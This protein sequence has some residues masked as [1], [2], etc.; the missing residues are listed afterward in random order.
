V[1]DGPRYDDLLMDITR[2]DFGP[3]RLRGM[4]AQIRDT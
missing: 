1:F 4:I 2:E 3:S